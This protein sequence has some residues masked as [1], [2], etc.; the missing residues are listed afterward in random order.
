MLGS[1]R[2]RSASSALFALVLLASVVSVQ[3]AVEETWVWVIG[4]LLQLGGF[5]F[6]FF[7][8]FSAFSVVCLCVD[9]Y[10]V[11]KLDANT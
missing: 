2:S 5:Y 4:A 11:M 6:V 1:S 10:L 3:A 7:A 9:L 8:N